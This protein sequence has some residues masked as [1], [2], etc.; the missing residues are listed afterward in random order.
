M[1][2][3]KTTRTT[4]SWTPERRAAQS[5]LMRRIR[6]WTRSTGPRTAAGKARSKMNAFKHGGYGASMNEF[7]ALLRRHNRF[8][9]TCVK[10]R[11]N[12]L[13]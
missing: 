2:A 7:C 11:G 6:P 13:L 1:T 9:R 10:N 5:A 12:E 8:L 4:T 3:R